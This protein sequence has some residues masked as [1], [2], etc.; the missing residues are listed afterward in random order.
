MVMPQ[1]DKYS[2][3]RNEILDQL[4][5]AL[6]GRVAEEMVFHDPTT[7][8]ANDI[9]KATAMARKMVTE[10]GMSERVG[11]IKLGQSN[12]EVFLGRD[13]GHQR[14]YSE[15]IAGV[16]DEEVRKLIENAHDEAWHVINDNRDVLDRLVLELLEKETLNGTELATIFEQVRKRPVRPTWLSS[17]SR[18]LS[19][20]PPVLTPAEREASA[21]NRNGTPAGYNRNG[22]GQN[23]ANGSNGHGG[24]HVANGSNGS[25]GSNGHGGSNGQR[26]APQDASGDRE[27]GQRIDDAAQ[28][29]ASPLAEVEPRTQVVEVPDGGRVDPSDDH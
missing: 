6:G 13:M 23:G 17:E 7:G 5:Y 19:D 12:G 1:D 21:L 26:P 8:A 29:G 2:T 11:A 28:A 27:L 20:L 18:L 10:Y 9:E 24:S 25:N 22:Y 16:V 4:A 15:E 3:T 14:D